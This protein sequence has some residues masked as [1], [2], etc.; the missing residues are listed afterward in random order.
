MLAETPVDRP[1]PF[2][3]SLRYLSAVVAAGLVAATPAGAET[4]NAPS[5]VTGMEATMTGAQL[6][7]TPGAHPSTAFLRS[8]QGRPVTVACVNGA[9]AL[10]GVLE[11]ESLVPTGNFDAAFLG[12]PAPW[13]AG[14]TSLTHALTRDVSATVDGCVVGRALAVAST[15]GFNSLGRALLQEGIDQQRLALAHHAAKFVAQDR[16][17]SRFPSARRLAADIAES[18][19]QMQVAYAPTVRRATRNDVVYVL[20]RGTDFKRVTLA[21]RQND[22][23]PVELEGRRRGQPTLINMPEESDVPVPDPDDGAGRLPPRR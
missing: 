19:P 13:P 23:Q 11:E 12:G 4:R 9:E 5:P 10:V 3:L 8:V 18:E 14:S 1:S 16:A 21:Y 6:T 15:F 20:G 2:R 7:V 17:N 22:G